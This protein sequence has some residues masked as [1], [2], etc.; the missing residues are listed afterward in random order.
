MLELALVLQ[1]AVAATGTGEVFGLQIGEP[2][3]LPRCGSI[4]GPEK[5]AC[6][7]PRRKGATRDI[8]RF[9]PDERPTVARGD[10]EV[11]VLD[12]K[13]EGVSFQMLGNAAAESVL[14][15]LKAKYGE[16]DTTTSGEWPNTVGGKLPWTSAVW[17]DEAGL[18][19]SYSTRTGGVLIQS[20]KS[21]RTTAEFVEGIHR[22][23]RKL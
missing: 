21:R 23:E 13:L 14:A 19:V 20:Q 11:I 2:L 4:T 18:N 17:N 10:I 15:Q 9:A 16:P 5:G 8:V 1:L 12:G 7:M 3:S 6:L 22:N